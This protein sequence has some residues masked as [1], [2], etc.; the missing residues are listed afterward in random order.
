MIIS[1]QKISVS[2]HINGFQYTTG[3]NKSESFVIDM[4]S[5]SYGGAN[6]ETNPNSRI[7]V[8]FPFYF[9]CIWNDTCFQYPLSCMSGNF[10]SYCWTFSWINFWSRRLILSFI[11][12]FFNCC[13]KAFLEKGLREATRRLLLQPLLI[14]LILVTEILSL[15]PHQEVRTFSSHTNRH[16]Q[17]II[18][19]LKHFPWFNFMSVWTTGRCLWE[20]GVGA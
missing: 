1:T 15:L 5:F 11:Y 10:R 17:F 6:K 18:C 16:R 9:F 2:D 14:P 20:A 4:E 8:K 13:R 12:L 19:L 7:T 3:D